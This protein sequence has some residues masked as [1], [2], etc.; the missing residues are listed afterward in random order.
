MN[1]NDFLH[2]LSDAMQT[3]EGWVA[4][5]GAAWPNFNPGNLKFAQQSGAVA[6]PSGFAKFGN[7]Y[8]GKQAQIMDLSYKLA[9]HNTLEEIISVYAPPSDN[10]TPAY[11]AA[12]IAYFATL[13]IVIGANDPIDQFLANFIKPTVLI[14]VNQLYNPADWHA[15]QAAIIQCA[16]YMPNYTFACHYSNADLTGDIVEVTNA[17]PPGGIF[18]GISAAAS[19]NVLA[20]YNDG[21]VLN[22]VIYDGKIMQGH[23]EPY[24]GCEFHGIK[25]P[26]APISSVM[27]AMYNGPMFA[28]ALA[29]VLWHELIHGLFDITQ[30]T[31]ILHAYLIAHGGY[32]QNTAADLEVVFTSDQLNT[33]AAVAILQ[34]DKRSLMQKL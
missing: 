25:E 14:A 15:V 29:R 26:Q 30:Q 23:S 27:S 31:D 5:G 1:K 2:I 20:P 18:S 24:G 12:V 6:L 21:Q 3:H 32:A 10:N 34:N 9:K 4:E 28:D 8:D 16:G 19:Q 7:F 11:I 13:N 22:L 17:N 33:N